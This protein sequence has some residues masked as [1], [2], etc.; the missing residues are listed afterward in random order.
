MAWQRLKVFS[1]YQHRFFT[2]AAKRYR[3]RNQMGHIKPPGIFAAPYSNQ[4]EEVRRSSEE[5][6]DFDSG[7][8]Q[9][10]GFEYFTLGPSFHSFS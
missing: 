8:T 5:S 3:R 9:P 6:S 2:V 4:M 1:A 7:F 10:S